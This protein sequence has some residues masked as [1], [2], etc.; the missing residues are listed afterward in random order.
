MADIDVV[1]GRS[2]SWIWWIVAIVAVL[3]IAMMLMRGSDREPATNAPARSSSTA[4]PV[5]AA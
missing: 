3:L 5:L 4:T 2:N 1:K